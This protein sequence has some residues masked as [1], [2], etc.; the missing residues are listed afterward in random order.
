MHAKRIKLEGTEQQQQRGVDYAQEESEDP[1]S[2]TR[3]V[4]LRL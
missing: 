3:C 4:R 1:P 2:K